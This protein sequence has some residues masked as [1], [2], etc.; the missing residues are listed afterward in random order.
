M[1]RGLVTILM[2]VAITGVFLYILIY[3]MFTSQHYKEYACNVVYN[4]WGKF[5]YLK[6]VF[7]SRCGFV[8]SIGNVTIVLENLSLCE[9]ESVGNITL[10]K[11]SVNVFMYNTLKGSSNV[12]FTYWV[13][14]DGTIYRF[15]DPLR[16]LTLKYPQTRSA[17][18]L[19]SNL[20][21]MV[22]IAE[23]LRINA[24]PYGV[25]IPSDRG[26]IT[27]ISKVNYVL[28]DKVIPAWN[29]TVIPPKNVKSDLK[30][31]VL[32]IAK[33]RKFWFIVQ[34]IFVSKNE[35]IGNYSIIEVTLLK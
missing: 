32:T 18:L 13:S 29:L 10:M 24:S 30:Y 17:K 33:L 25:K 15:Y 2:L 7:K 4:I 14:K 19:L 16:N 31:L 34:A 27:S 8:V 28:N 23:F 21:P 11:Y 1:G 9:V 22:G 3:P 20:V 26:V 5:R 12:T 6:E 35:C